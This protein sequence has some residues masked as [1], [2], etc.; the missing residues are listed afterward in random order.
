MDR[1]RAKDV[2]H[3][4]QEAFYL[5]NHLC[6]S[7]SASWAGEMLSDL[8]QSSTS[9]TEEYLET[10]YHFSV[11]TDSYFY[12]GKDFFD[13]MVLLLIQLF[14]S[15]CFKEY[16][17]AGDYFEK[18]HADHATFLKFLS[19]YMALQKHNGSVLLFVG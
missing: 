7:K 14:F 16:L 13:Q 5:L 4:L 3:D 10:P 8:V 17:Q 12:T 2:C 19:N 18:S 1:F 11:F 6:L 15:M 9:L